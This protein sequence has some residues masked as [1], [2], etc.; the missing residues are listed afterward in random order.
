MIK[1]NE[2]ARSAGEKAERSRERAR[3][4]GSLRRE[5][6]WTP[7]EGGQQVLEGLWRQQCIVTLI[8]Y[9]RQ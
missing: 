1:Q 3:E 5:K 9:S 8:A 4:A 6:G 7:E 2:A